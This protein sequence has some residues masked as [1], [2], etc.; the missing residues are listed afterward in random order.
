MLLLFLDFLLIDDFCIRYYCSFLCSTYDELTKMGVDFGRLSA[1]QTEEEER[2]ASAPPSRSNS[3]NASTTS[4]KSY[5]S[6]ENDG[7][8]PVEVINTDSIETSE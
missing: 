3:R 4:L 7:L 8:D 2:A 1:N 5:M 6:D